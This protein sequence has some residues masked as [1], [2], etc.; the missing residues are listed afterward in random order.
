[1]QEQEDRSSPQEIFWRDP[2]AAARAVGLRYVHDGMPG[3]RRRRC[4][5]G[6]AFF[7]P[8]GEL[9]RD[10]QAL[11]R[12]RALVIPPAW[13]DVWIC[14][15]ATGHLQAT[16]RDRRGRKQYLYHAS[17]G[18]IRNEVKFARILHFADTLPV[19]RQQVDHDLRKRN[20][21]REKMLAAVVRLLE[22]SLI[23]IGNEEYLRQNLSFGLTTLR[24]DHVEIED[25]EIRFSFRGKA[26]KWHE[27]SVQD[28]R[29]SRVLRQ[30]LDLP[31]QELFR[32]LDK[33]EELRA[34]SSEEVN[35]Y[36]RQATGAD[37]TAKDIRTWHATVA[38][39]AELQD[40][41]PWRSPAEAKRKV[42]Q[43]VRQVARLLGNRPAAS[44]KYYIHP[45]ILDSY[46]HGQLLP[47]LDRILSRV[48]ENFPPELSP[49]EYAVKIFLAWKRLQ[50]TSQ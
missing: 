47:S 33:E 21:P 35:D 13:Q 6:F 10:R 31:G 40:L 18:E 49:M 1:M 2:Q 14:C 43:A 42:G 5:R 28:R 36:L 22:K 46:L 32:Y 44:R 11:E 16:G 24:R 17:W 7:G 50:E 12:V 4:G 48:D 29:V 39:A 8:D 23:R 25:S 27:R 9:I 15:T 19:L 34:I 3:I 37:F 30:I 26:G 45:E 20:F 41:G 38:A